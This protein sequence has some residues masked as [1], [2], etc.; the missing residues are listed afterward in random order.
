ME[1]SCVRDIVNLI[2]LFTQ[3]TFKHPEEV[4]VW[5]NAAG[6]WTTSIPYG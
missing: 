2:G 1:S 6:G 3:V 4:S 5:K